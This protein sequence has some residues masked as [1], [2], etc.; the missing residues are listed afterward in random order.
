MSRQLG[1][2]NPERMGTATF[3]ILCS[4]LATRYL[5]FSNPIGL[6][7]KAYDVNPSS[8]P[9]LETCIFKIK[10]HLQITN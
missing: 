3:G 1:L 9:Y 2:S 5:C 8:L 10:E 4:I 7:F 6:F